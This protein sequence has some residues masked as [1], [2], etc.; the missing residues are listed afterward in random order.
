MMGIEWGGAIISGVI[1]YRVKVSIRTLF[2]SCP[3]PRA[4]PYGATREHHFKELRHPVF[5]IHEKPLKM[6][7]ILI[8]L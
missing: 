3:D 6:C 2:A 7:Y 5:D 4:L 1:V 8:T